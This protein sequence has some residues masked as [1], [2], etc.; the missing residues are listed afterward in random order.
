MRLVGEKVHPV[1]Q[2]PLGDGNARHRVPA[3]GTHVPLVGLDE[4]P[5]GHP[6]PICG[7]T[8]GGRSSA[9]ATT[10][11]ASRTRQMPRRSGSPWMWTL[12]FG[13]HED[14]TPTLGYEATREGRWR[15][16]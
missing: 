10:T 6:A 8:G 11:S 16:S 14:C 5:W 2:L 15:R 7:T 12:A 13:Y 3:L 1:G 9:R 4:Y